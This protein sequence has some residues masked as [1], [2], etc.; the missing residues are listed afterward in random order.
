MAQIRSGQPFCVIGAVAP[1]INRPQGIVGA[2]QRALVHLSGRPVRRRRER[3]SLAQFNFDTSVVSCSFLL[4]C[5]CFVYVSGWIEEAWTCATRCGDSLVRQVIKGR[6]LG[7]EQ[8][9]GFI[10]GHSLEIQHGN[11]KSCRHAV[12]KAK[13]AL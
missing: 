2:A 9:N 8:V 3:D 6:R 12:W 10:A 1:L 7:N 11:E 5:F 4:A 13:E